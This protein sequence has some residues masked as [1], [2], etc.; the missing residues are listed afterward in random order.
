MKQVHAWAVWNIELNE[1]CVYIDNTGGQLGA[2][3]FFGNSSESAKSQALRY[4]NDFGKEA[5]KV[6]GVRLKRI[7]ITV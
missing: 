4:L 2:A 3:I 7:T 5:A 1:P 6:M